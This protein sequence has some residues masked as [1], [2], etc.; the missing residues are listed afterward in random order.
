M[1]AAMYMYAYRK[2]GNFCEAELFASFVI[3]H[4]LAKICSCEKFFL[5]K[6]LEPP[7]G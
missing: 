7:I 2:V 4:Q 1:L 3:K 6:F 5:Q